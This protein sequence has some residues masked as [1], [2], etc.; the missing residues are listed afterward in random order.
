MVVTIK[1]S[2]V[3]VSHLQFT[4]IVL[5]LLGGTERGKSLLQRSTIHPS[6]SGG[7]IQ[8]RVVWNLNCM[9]LH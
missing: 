1:Y 9:T 5:G 6:F 8:R 4:R 2:S 7:K 3:A